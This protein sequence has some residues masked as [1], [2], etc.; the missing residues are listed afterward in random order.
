MLFPL[1]IYL[2]KAPRLF[3][4]IIQIHQPEYLVCFKKTKQTQPQKTLT[5]ST[6]RQSCVWCIWVYT[7]V[8]FFFSGIW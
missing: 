7:K 6:A 5:C 2:E 3:Y 4:Y 8:P 1:L